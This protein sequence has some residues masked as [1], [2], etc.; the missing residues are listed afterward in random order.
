M[1][2][3]ELKY[4]MHRLLICGHTLLAAVRLLLGWH[5]CEKLLLKE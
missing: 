3:V 2:L 5:C 1:K 4:G